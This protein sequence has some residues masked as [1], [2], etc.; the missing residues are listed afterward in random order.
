MGNKQSVLTKEVNKAF[1]YYKFIYKYTFYDEEK[2]K[3]T[4]RLYL[5]I[6]PNNKFFNNSCL[7]LYILSFNSNFARA[8]QIHKAHTKTHYDKMDRM[9]ERLLQIIGYIQTYKTIDMKLNMN[10]KT[11]KG[12][13]LYINMLI[14]TDSVYG[15]IQLNS[16]RKNGDTV[17]EYIATQCVEWLYNKGRHVP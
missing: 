4:I 14:G 17:I 7:I 5:D 6:Q 3:A 13:V 16:L 11:C 10:Y 9:T 15:P 8:Y 2:V 12:L 1:M